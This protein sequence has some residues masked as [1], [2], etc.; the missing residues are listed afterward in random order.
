MYGYDTFATTTTGT[1]TAISGE[2]IGQV[3]KNIQTGY[4]FLFLIFCKLPCK[5]A[6]CSANALVF[7]TVLFFMR[8]LLELAWHGKCGGG[9]FSCLS[10]KEKRG[11]FSGPPPEYSVLCTENVG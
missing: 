1:G 8:F 3:A 10:H 7:K 11:G 2:K 4:K 5:N 9:I 6:I